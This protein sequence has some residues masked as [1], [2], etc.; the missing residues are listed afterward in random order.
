[1]DIGGPLNFA[2]SLGNFNTMSGP[3]ARAQLAAFFKKDEGFPEVGLFIDID[4]WRR[5]EKD[6]PGAEVV[7]AVK[8][9]AEAA[10]A[11]HEGIRDL[12]L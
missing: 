11:R 4:Y 1:V 12:I 7:S 6:V 9:F 3:M 5:P 2:D 8:S 10:W